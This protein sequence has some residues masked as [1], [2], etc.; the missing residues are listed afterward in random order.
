MSNP[1][2]LESPLGRVEIDREARIVRLVR[3]SNRIEPD[4]IDGVVEELRRAVPLRER[5]RFVLLQDMRLGPLIRDEELEKKL[6]IAVPK[7]TAGFAARAVLLA[8][9]VGVL[10]AGRFIRAAGGES[11]MFTDEEEAM[12][13]LR[14]EAAKLPTGA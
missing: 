14:A 12:R 7:L 10:Q 9:A 8:S 5:P 3:S 2:I 4:T 6:A 1:E 13:Y 11:R